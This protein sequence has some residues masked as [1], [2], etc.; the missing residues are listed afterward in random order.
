[1]KQSWWK[2]CA[3]C[4]RH[5]STRVTQQFGLEVG[6]VSLSLAIEL[7]HLCLVRLEGWP[8]LLWLTT[9]QR[10]PQPLRPYGLPDKATI[11]R[12]PAL[13][14][15]PLSSSFLLEVYQISQHLCFYSK[16]MVLN[17]I[18]DHVMLT[19]ETL[20]FLS[21]WPHYRLWVWWQITTACL[22]SLT[23]SSIQSPTR[24]CTCVDACTGFCST[25]SCFLEP[26]TMA[27]VSSCFT[28]LHN[29]SSHLPVCLP[30]TNPPFRG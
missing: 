7:T 10:T 12:A 9:W 3:Q 6:P 20:T 21:L 23:I 27:S 22:I 1:M 25:L 17:Y 14:I 13:S 5:S 24:M 8:Q 15:K 16:L 2:C 18:S 19:H 28:L 11:T 26:S 29:I 30:H 4:H